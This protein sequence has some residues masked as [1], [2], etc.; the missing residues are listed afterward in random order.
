[1]G[2]FAFKVCG[3]EQCFVCGY[4]GGSCCAFSVSA[5]RRMA[6]DSWHHRVPGTGQNMS[7]C[8]GSRAIHSAHTDGLSCS[9]AVEAS[10]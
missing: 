2:D 3:S 4:W 10:F 1:M 6:G 8:L 9:G 7:W 5:G